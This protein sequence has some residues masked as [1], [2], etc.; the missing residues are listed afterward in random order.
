MQPGEFWSIT[1]YDFWLEYDMRLDA[2]EAQER[3]IK[4]GRGEAT[5]EDFAFA[6]Q[7]HEAKKAKKAA[8]RAAR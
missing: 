3:A 6:R 7:V 4:R 5:D 2:I 1:P 8:E